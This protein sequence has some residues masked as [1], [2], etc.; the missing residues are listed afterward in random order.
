VSIAPE[1]AGKEI[2]KIMG[3][4][5]VMGTSTAPD[6][7]EVHKKLYINCAGGTEVEK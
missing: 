1:I 6:D 4:R 5:K 3:F 7:I 2:K